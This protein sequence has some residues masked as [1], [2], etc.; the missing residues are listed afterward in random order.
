MDRRDAVKMSLGAALVGTLA[1]C[2][3]GGEEHQK[4]PGEGASPDEASKASMD[5]VVA[6]QTAMGSGE[7]EKMQS[8]MADDMVWHNEGDKTLPWIG[9][10]EG[11]EAILKFLPIFSENLKTTLW[12]TEASFASGDTVAMFG[13][14]NGTTT[15]SGKDTGTFTW[16]LQAKVR[17]GQVILWHWYEDSFAV[18]QAYHGRS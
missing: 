15:K 10:W 6:F 16:A 14:M 7:M 17:D 8:L 11:K 5:T 4:A 2:G 13:K 18:S 1:A 3:R 9:V 12:E